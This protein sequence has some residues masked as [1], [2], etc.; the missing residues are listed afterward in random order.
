MPRASRHYIPGYV[1]HITIIDA[2]KRN[3]QLKFA[4][5]RRRWIELDFS[6]VPF[7]FAEPIQLMAV[8]LI[9]F[10]LIVSLQ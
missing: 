7:S 6:N 5:D 10:L 1:W 3:F 2:T 8:W 9:A 4:R